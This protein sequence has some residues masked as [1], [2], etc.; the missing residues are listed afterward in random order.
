MG[1]TFS[2]GRLGWHALY[3]PLG[4]CVCVCIHVHTQAPSSLGAVCSEPHRD[5]SS[6][7]GGSTSSLWSSRSSTPASPQDQCSPWQ[8]ELGFCHQAWLS[9]AP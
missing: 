3:S 1:L 4:L 2:P 6:V 9:A 8:T 7:G 5:G